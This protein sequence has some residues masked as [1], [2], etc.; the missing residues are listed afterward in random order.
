[1]TDSA[2]VGGTAS[3]DGRG[4]IAC[5]VCDVLHDEVPVSAGAKAR[6]SRCGTV[7]YAPRRSAMTQIVML[8]ATAAILMIAAVFFP[9]LELDAGGLNQRSSVFDAVMAFSEGWMAPLS[10]AVAATVVLLPFAR[11]CAIAYA[12]GPMAIGWHPARYAEAAMRWAEAVRPWAMAE[13]FILGV[14]V[15]LVKV[16]GL[17]KVT[18]GPAFWAFAALVLVTVLKDSVICKLSVWKTLEERRNT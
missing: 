15:A 7:L 13:I 8:A 3:L 6:C 17:A 1:M 18:L 14:A 4:L 16:A 11:L 5:P 10:A 9:F 12:L 2:E